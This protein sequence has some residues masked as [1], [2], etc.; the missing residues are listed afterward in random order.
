M[1]ETF[2]MDSNPS[3]TSIPHSTRDSRGVAPRLRGFPRAALLVTMWTSLCF[4]AEPPKNPVAIDF[5][6]AGYQAGGHILPAIP[7]TVSVRP[8][9]GD[10]TALLQSAID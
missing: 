10:D 1:C 6:Y 5:S 9:G 7:A 8:S 4:A 3:R 2:Y